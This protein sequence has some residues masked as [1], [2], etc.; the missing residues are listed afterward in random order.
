[1]SKPAANPFFEVD[2]SKFADMS[3]MASEFKM[4]SMEPMMAMQRRNLEAM[5]AVNQAAYENMQTLARRQMDMMRQGMEDMMGMMSGMM[6]APSSPQEKVMRQA[7]ASKMAV[8]KCIAN[9]K[10]VAE[11]LNK[12]N[13]QAMEIVA[14]RLSESMEEIRGM[15]QP[16]QRDAA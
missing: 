7:E 16:Q 6:A 2:F 9:A 11:T 13:A 15:M 8:E 10:D 12:S 1:M 14:N 4:P 5:S 3:K